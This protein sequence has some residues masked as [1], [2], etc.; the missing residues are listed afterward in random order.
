MNIN[1]NNNKKNSNSN[2]NSNN[3]NN[4]QGTASRG[5][6]LPGE[7][8]HD[9]DEGR[10][11]AWHLWRYAEAGLFLHVTG[12]PATMLLQRFP[13]RQVPLEPPLPL[14]GRCTS[15]WRSE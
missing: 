11:T 10:Q 13:S 8:V 7:G 15:G 4:R 1:K 6:R 14:M 9:V 3:N 12:G 5:R 2:K